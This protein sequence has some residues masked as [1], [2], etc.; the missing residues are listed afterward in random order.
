MK[1]IKKNFIFL[2]IGFI[3]SVIILSIYISKISFFNFLD[4]KLKD[5]RFNS[6][7]FNDVDEKIAIVAIDEKSVNE[8]GRW[9]WDRK[10]IA[11]LINNINFYGAKTVALDIVFSEHT[12]ENSDRL[13]A[14]AISAKQNI[15]LGYF[16]REEKTELGKELQLKFEDKRIKILKISPN[17]NE[18]PILSYEGVELNIPDIEMSS[19]YA[20]FFN[21]VPDKDGIIRK[22]NLV[23]VHDGL[24]YPSLSLCALKNFIGDEIL[25]NIEEY[26][27]DKI[28]IGNK[29]IHCDESGAMTINYYTDANKFKFFSAVDLIKKRLDKNAFKD[30]LV[31][32]GATEIGI[33]DIRATPVN[34]VLPGIF[35][36]ATVASNILKDQLIIKDG[37]VILLDIIFICLFAL[38]LSFCLSFVRKTLGSLFIFLIFF[39]LYYFL[40]LEIFNIYHLDISILYPLISLTITYMS[41]EAYRNLFEE[42]QSRFLKKAFTSYVSPALVNEI[43]K[44][45]DILKLG[46][47]TKEVT[48]LFSDIRDFTTISEKL[49]PESLVLLLNSYLSPMTDIVLKNG[50]TLDKYIG[51]AIM[52]LF[53][54]PL[55]LEDHATKGCL[56]ALMMLRK[57]NEVNQDLN[58][59]G[60]PKIDIGIGINTGKVVVGNMGTEVRFDYTAIGDSVNLASRLEGMNKVYGTHIIISEFT[61]EKI[62]QKSFKLRLLDIIKVKGKS[63][64]VA[65]YEISEDLND[66]LIN[67]FGE[68]L[69]LY[70]QRDFLKAK[71]IFIDLFKEYKDPPSRVF[72]DRCD[73]YIKNPPQ[74]GWDGVY[75][76]KTK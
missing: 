74:E 23:M 32:I 14:K 37:R 4:L 45:P 62:K 54:A 42:K 29:R 31:F 65:I 22:L 12:S 27:I 70:F 72:I 58:K 75:V 71:K 48:I 18:I 7:T 68:A 21:I 63:K 64:P 51:D 49:E 66:K 40:N 11:E 50:G 47:Q 19:N 61:A 38:L 15:V 5:V 24:I 17:V 35:I 57:L 44:N 60:L 25:L 69:N 13:L 28:Y 1:N 41:C 6:R 36:H 52:A 46:G 26:G 8:L 2:S 34:P 53:N 76:A 3:S 59:K 56:T 10:L 55:D 30:K 20:G 39:I 67:F 33:S 16:F 9:P 73:E 43:I